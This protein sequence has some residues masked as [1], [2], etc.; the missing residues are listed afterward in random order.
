MLGEEKNF[1][2][3]GIRLDQCLFV[4]VVKLFLDFWFLIHSTKEARG[5]LMR[6]RLIISVESQ[7]K[8]R[9]IMSIEM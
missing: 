7:K 6:D 5:V 4:V 2:M 9:Y 3:G 1:Q 8:R